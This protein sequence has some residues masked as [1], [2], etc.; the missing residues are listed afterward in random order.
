[1][2]GDEAAE[3]RR[4]TALIDQATHDAEVEKLPKAVRAG[5]TEEQKRE[6]LKAK[7]LAKFPHLAATAPTES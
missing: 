4:L 6:E 5:K 1:M 3:D 7:M 2:Q